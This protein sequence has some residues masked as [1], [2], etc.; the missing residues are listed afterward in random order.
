MPTVREALNAAAQL[1]NDQRY[2]DSI[3]AYQAVADQNPEEKATCHGQ[4]GACYFLKGEYSTA[5]QYYKRAKDNQ[6]NWAAMDDEI[7]QAQEA[8]ARALRETTPADQR[9]ATG[10]VNQRFIL[11]GVG[12][13]SGLGTALLLW[14][15]S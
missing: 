5:I 3:A 8:M 13:I 4:I 14:L 1:L 7:Q 11:V 9:G 6:A 10:D 2:D 12:L 15:V